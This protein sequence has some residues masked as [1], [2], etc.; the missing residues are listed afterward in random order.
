[1]KKLS[2]HGWGAGASGAHGGLLKPFPGDGH[3][4]GRELDHGKV[5][6][7]AY[8]I[9]GACA[10]AASDLQHFFA[11]PAFEL[12]KTGNVRLDEILA[13]FYFIKIFPGSDVACRMPY[14]A[15]PTIPIL[16]D[17]LNSGRQL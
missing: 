13:L 17:I 12:R 5:S 10:N 11:L 3:A 2:I 7:P 16:L 9:A 8:K 14:I 6:P 1:M 4:L 15:R